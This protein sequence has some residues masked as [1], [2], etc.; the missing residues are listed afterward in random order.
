MDYSAVPL[1]RPGVIWAIS[2]ERETACLVLL[3]AFA[4][5][6]CEDIQCPPNTVD[7]ASSILRSHN[8]SPLRCILAR[9]WDSGASSVWHLI[10][11][12][13]GSTNLAPLDS[14]LVDPRIRP[15]R[16]RCFDDQDTSVPLGAGLRGAQDLPDFWTG[17]SGLGTRSAIRVVVDKTFQA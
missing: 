8:L 12:S 11:G 16:V 6:P 2:S 17:R 3:C 15:F 13:S 14:P 5:D 7:R 1:F 4:A 10:H 9:L